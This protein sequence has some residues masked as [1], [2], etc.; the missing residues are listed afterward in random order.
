MDAQCYVLDRNGGRVLIQ[1]GNA[2]SGRYYLEIRE[3]SSS[4]TFQ[5]PSGIPVGAVG[6]DVPHLVAG[7]NGEIDFRG[8][9][10]KLERR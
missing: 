6:Q 9:R 4:E 10:Y 2:D 5:V 8:S 7:T 3:G 1:H